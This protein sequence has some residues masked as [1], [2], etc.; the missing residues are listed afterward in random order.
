MSAKGGS[1]SPSPDNFLAKGAD[2][3]AAQPHFI[4]A[5]AL[6]ERRSTWEATATI[7]NGVFL[8]VH[9]NRVR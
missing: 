1:R 6:G 7:P 2:N 9:K 3:Q 8:F 4:F 5:N